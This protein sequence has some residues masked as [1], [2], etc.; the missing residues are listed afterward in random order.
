MGLIKSF[1]TLKST[2]SPFSSSQSI[3]SITDSTDESISNSNENISNSLKHKRS[4]S[5]SN[6]ISISRLNRALSK[7]K[8][9]I[10]Q[11]ALEVA[12]QKVIMSEK[13]IV[14]T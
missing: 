11:I 4:R 3:A 1:K 7:K 9:V 14:L 13:L 6:K 8:Q 10:Y 5:D 12:I 2:F